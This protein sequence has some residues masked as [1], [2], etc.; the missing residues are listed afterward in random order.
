[1]SRSI[2]TQCRWFSD[3]INGSVKAPGQGRFH[4]QIIGTRADGADDIANC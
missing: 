3:F 4:H 1:M 2:S